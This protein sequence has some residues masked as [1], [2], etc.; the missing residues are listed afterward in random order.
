MGEGLVGGEE[1]VAAGEEVPLQPAL[2]DVFGQDLHDP[3]VPG[4]IAVRALR[5]A[6]PGLSGRLVQVVEAVGGGLVRSDDPE[7][8]P[9]G[10]VVHDPG[11]EVPQD[12]RRFVEGAARLVDG[13][14][15]GVERRHRQRPQQPATVRVRDGAQ[16]AV[17]LGDTGEDLRGGAPV[18][19]EELL[20]PVR[21]QPVLQLPQVPGILAHPGERT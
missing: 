10:G 14:G 1:A 7:V 18:G 17:A 2:A 5:A 8:P 4:Q 11:E 15:V 9:L 20:G 19:V 6:L 12:A 16:A 21:A 3:A 13:D